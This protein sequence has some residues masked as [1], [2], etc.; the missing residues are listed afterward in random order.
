MNHFLEFFDAVGRQK[1]DRLFFAIVDLSKEVS[2]KPWGEGKLAGLISLLNADATNHSIEIGSVII[3]KEFQRTH[4]TTNAAGLLLQWCFSKLGM[5]RVQWE[6]HYHNEASITTAKKMHFRYEGIIR[7]QRVLP[8]EKAEFGEHIEGHAIEEIPGRHTAMLSMCWDDWE[9]G[10][11][12]VVAT[13]M[14]RTI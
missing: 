12:D 1:A 13:R 3:G 2:N 14:A 6:A 5:R 7:W 10:V 11:K 9:A 4:V 8:R